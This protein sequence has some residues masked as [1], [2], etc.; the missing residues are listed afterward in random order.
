MD[1]ETDDDEDEYM[2]TLLPGAK[3]PKLWSINVVKSFKEREVVLRLL[4][5]FKHVESENKI[6][7]ACSFDHLYGKI[8][9]EAYK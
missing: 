7:S 4:N 2:K 6:I 1:H 3:D 5:K 9:V 8:Y